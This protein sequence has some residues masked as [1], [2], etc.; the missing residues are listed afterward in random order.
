MM[1]APVPLFAVLSAE[2]F[3]SVYPLLI[4]PGFYTLRGTCRKINFFHYLFLVECLAVAVTAAHWLPSI[5]LLPVLLFCFFLYFQAERRLYYLLEIKQSNIVMG[6]SPQ[7]LK[8]FCRIYVLNCCKNALLPTIAG[9]ILGSVI[10]FSSAFAWLVSAGC[11]LFFWG[12]YMFL[13]KYS[14]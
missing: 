14:H 5:I 11:C 7:D 13:R 12:S 1:F 2:P 8:I 9:S 3:A 10:I 6:D 4:L